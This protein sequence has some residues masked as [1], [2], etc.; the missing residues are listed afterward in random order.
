MGLYSAGF[1]IGRRLAYEINSHEQLPAHL[2]A[3]LARAQGRVVRKPI[4]ANLRLKANQGFR[5]AFK[6]GFQA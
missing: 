4:N 2:V 5:L 6:S 1:I 3:Q